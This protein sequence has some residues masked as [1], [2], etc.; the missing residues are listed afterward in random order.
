MTY[1]PE[2]GNIW[3]PHKFGDDCPSKRDD[4]PDGI[5]RMSFMKG[6]GFAFDAIN[7]F[8]EAGNAVPLRTFSS[9]E[10]FSPEQYP[11][12]TIVNFAYDQALLSLDREKSAPMESIRG[13]V[14]VV[15]EYTSKRGTVP[16]VI[17][18]D[19]AVIKSNIIQGRNPLYKENG[20][21]IGFPITE[22]AARHYK[23]PKQETLT[24]ITGLVVYHM[25]DG[26]RNRERS[27]FQVPLLNRGMR[28]NPGQA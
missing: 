7:D 17:C 16:G 23:T 26:V 8:F 14:G 22:G 2:D 21:I 1:S 25:G 5:R 24:R 6:A 10:I 20:I 19:S 13:Y 11:Q 15:Y 9:N 12:G 18:F 4:F 3:S 27:V 28:L